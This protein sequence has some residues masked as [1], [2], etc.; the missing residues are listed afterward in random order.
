[1]SYHISVLTEQSVYYNKSERVSN[2]YDNP[3][4][5]KMLSPSLLPM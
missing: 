5:R 1:V 4:I 3:I 2:V